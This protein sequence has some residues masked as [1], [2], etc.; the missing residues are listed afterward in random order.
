MEILAERGGVIGLNGCD[1]I[2]GCTGGE[3]PLEMLCRHVEHEIQ[4]VGIEYVGLG[5]DFCDSYTEAEPGFARTIRPADCLGNHSRAPELT[6][7]LLQRGMSR[8]DAEKFIGGNW[9][10]FFR[11]VLPDRYIRG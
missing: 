4:T 3:D 5:L 1:S 6:A 11:K 8:E 9:I 10:S 7:A 2:V